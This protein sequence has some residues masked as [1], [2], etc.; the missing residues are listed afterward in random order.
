MDFVALCDV[1]FIMYTFLRFIQRMKISIMSFIKI[2]SI[3]KEKN[4][5]TLRKADVLLIVITHDQ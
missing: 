1:N 2:L 4:V 5:V 3:L